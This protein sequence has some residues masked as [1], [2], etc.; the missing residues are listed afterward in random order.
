MGAL[1]RKLRTSG[2]H[3]ITFYCPAC[4]TAHSVR[5]GRNGWEWNYNVRFPTFTPSLLTIYE[6]LSGNTRCHCYIRNGKIEYLPDSTHLLRG[7]TIDLPDWPFSD[8]TDWSA[9]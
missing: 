3:L 8:D 1:G 4:Q 6:T 5:I 2:E 7:Q 9:A